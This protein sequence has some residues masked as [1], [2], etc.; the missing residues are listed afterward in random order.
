MQE[1]YSAISTH[2]QVKYKNKE[3]GNI[4]T[5]TINWKG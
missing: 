5:K 2:I 3:I 4:L 1:G